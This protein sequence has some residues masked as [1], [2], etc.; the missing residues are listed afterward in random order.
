[1]NPSNL[2]ISVVILNWNR[3]DEIKNCIE[4]MRKIFDG[5]IVVV[6]QGSTDGSKEYLSSRTDINLIS[7]SENLGVAGG[8]NVGNKNATGDI[9]IS[10]DSDA[11]FDESFSFDELARE[12]KNDPTLSA[13]AFKIMNP[14]NN[15]LDNWPHTYP[16]DY[17]D[18]RFESSRFHGCGHA[19]RKSHFMEVDMYDETLFFNWEESDLCYRFLAKGYRVVYIPDFVVYHDRSPVAR[20]QWNSGR[21]YY[22]VRNRLYMFRK[23]FTGVKHKVT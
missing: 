22:F 21:Y 20:V 11:Y 23:Y 3:L 1:M 19:I 8:R 4:Q 5:E 14:N 16:E 17:C 7:L 10:I 9:L 15:K 2:N 13:I 18:R 12:F 6:D